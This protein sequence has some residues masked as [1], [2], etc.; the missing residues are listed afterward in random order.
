MNTPHPWI[1]LDP[2]RYPTDLFCH[3]NL[4][5]EE[6]QRFGVTEYQREYRFDQAVVRAEICFSGDTALFLW[7]NGAL[8]ASGPPWIGGDFLGN[9][10]PRPEHYATRLVLTPNTDT[11]FFYARVRRGP[12]LLCEYSKGQTAFLLWATLTMEDGSQRRICTDSTWL[13]RPDRRFSK[14]LC[15]DQR[16]AEAPWAKAVPCEDR[17]NALL[18]PLAP[19]CH[20]TVFPA[21]CSFSLRAEETLRR[22]ADF[23]R[24]HAG[25]LFVRLRCEG[26]VHLKIRCCERAERGKTEVLELC[27]SGE[28]LGLFLHSAGQMEIEINNRSSASAEVTIGLLTSYYPITEEARTY[29]DDEE[30]NQVLRLCRNNLQYCRQSIHLDSPKHCEPLACT[31][32]YYIESLMTAFSF[33]DL[34]LAK[35]DLR[36]TAGLLRRQNGRIFHTTYSLIWVLMLWDVYRFTA[37]DSLLK[38][39]ADALSLLLERFEGYLGEDG[40]IETPPDYMF[41]DWLV[42]DGLSLHHPPKALGQ[43]CLNLFAFGAQQTAVKIYRRLSLLKEASRCEERAKRL[44]TAIVELL[45][46]TKRGLFFEGLDTPT[47]E[48]LLGQYMPQNVKKRYVRKHANVLAAYF[49]ILPREECRRILK[50]VMEEQCEGE[51]QPYFLHF[52]LEAI[53]RNGLREEYTLS[54]LQ[55]WKASAKEFPKGLV[56]GFY[57]PEP[58]YRFDYSHAWGGTPLYALPMALSG[59]ELSEEGFAAIRLS[60]SLLGLKRAT[61]EIP[62]PYGKITLRQEEGKAPE[63]RIPKGITLLS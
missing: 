59:L 34:T 6:E 1:S 21:P 61:A 32:D 17:W 28:H 18:S 20:E 16:L 4:H 8:A 22:T 41:V 60:P 25:Y 54:V 49:G 2:Q 46:D 42:V 47:P 40:L 30:L 35:E 19:L 51:L 7:V 31:G 10:D 48:P 5:R 62:T 39:C 13:A 27:E 12:L 9:E 37:D 14:A 56:E 26:E 23:D 53:L 36:K 38:D 45:Y 43:T 58:G 33:G 57:A 50:Q 3:I 63:L 29:T 52:L 15:Y 11:F 44:K 55:R 24:I